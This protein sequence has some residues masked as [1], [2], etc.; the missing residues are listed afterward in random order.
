MNRLYVVLLVL[1][2]IWIVIAV[3]VFSEIKKIYT[4]G[5]PYTNK[6]LTIWFG[7]WA[8]HHLAVILASIYHVWLLPI[9]TKPASWGGLLILISG[10]LILTAGMIAFGTFERS[11]GKDTS[12]LVTNGIYRWSRNPQ[13]IGW[14]MILLGFSIIGRS[15]FALALT[16]VFMVVLYWYTVRLAEPYLE[17]L[18]G[19]DYT[20]YK[21]K[22]AR[23]IG[24][25]K[26][27]VIG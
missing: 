2:S 4:K 9:D 24:T 27:K 1:I 21:T 15:G 11:A 20:N 26:R 6:L 19:D 7:M 17:L 10:I 12:K 13:F 8:V 16:F 23:W 14:A 22:T 3:Y 25:S 5:K 18:F